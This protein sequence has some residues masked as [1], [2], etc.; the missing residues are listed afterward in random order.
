MKIKAQCFNG[1]AT[2]RYVLTLQLFACNVYRPGT[3]YCSQKVGNLGPKRA[4]NLFLKHL[5]VL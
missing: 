4:V 1:S 5:V 2:L 3:D